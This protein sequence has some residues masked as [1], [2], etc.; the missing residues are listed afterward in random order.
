MEFDSKEF[1]NFVLK[2]GVIGFFR[3][4]ITLAS[5]RRSHHY[6]NWRNVAKDTFLLEQAADHLLSF[7]QQLGLE[8]KCFLGA[9]EGAT[10]LAV[11]AQYKWAKARPDYAPG[12]YPIS[13][14]RGK[15]KDHGE[16]KDR[17]FVGTPQGPTIVIE[18]TTTT[19]GTLLATIK[20]LQ[21]I[22]VPVI[23]A[24]VLVNR[25]ETR[26]D[27]R[28]AKQAVEELGVPYHA[29]CDLRDILPSLYEQLKPDEETRSAVDAYFEKYGDK[30]RP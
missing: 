16:A 5:G 24:V 10:K 20:K 22:E 9:P 12:A 23:A 27:G 17:Y 4:P 2:N 18:D 8:P 13:M 29:M 21:E 25:N 1:A 7:T 14:A 15:P 11:L 28:S 19:G 30:I 3:D 6:V 26:D